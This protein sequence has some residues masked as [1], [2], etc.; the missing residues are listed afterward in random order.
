VTNVS[1]EA[2]KKKKNKNKNIWKISDENSI[3]ENF[4]CHPAF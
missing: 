2:P 1:K 3:P 4:S